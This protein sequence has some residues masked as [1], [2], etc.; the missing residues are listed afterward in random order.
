MKVR[1][2]VERLATYGCIFRVSAMVRHRNEVFDAQSFC[3]GAGVGYIQ[4]Y[5]RSGCLEII[6]QGLAALRER[7]GDQ[8]CKSGRCT[9][10]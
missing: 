2:R 4:S 1:R 6:A 8:L 7:L 3:P 9:G 5:R 10:G